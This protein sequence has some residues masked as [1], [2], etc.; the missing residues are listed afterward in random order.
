M[1]ESIITD[2]G[3]VIY[4]E[5]W[6]TVEKKLNENYSFSFKDF[7]NVFSRYWDD[8]KVGETSFSDF[9]SAI[10]IGLNLESNPKNIMNLSAAFKS[11]WTNSDDSVIQY[12][13]Q[14]K[15][16]GIKIIGFTNSCLENESKI[17]EDRRKFEFFDRIYMS[18]KEKIKKPDASSY[19]KII[20]EN[21]LLPER[22]LL[23]DD[24]E[25]NTG[26]AKGIGIKVLTYT[27]LKELK[28]YVENMLQ[29]R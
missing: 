25:R 26:G 22:C 29:D 7:M 24:K 12:L 6:D 11:I 28:N 8:Y 23:V 10:C 13:E 17:I 4:P 3:N 18:H 20:K 2:F 14:L 27:S 19:M 5:R 15:N 1:L 21:N 9:W 16:K